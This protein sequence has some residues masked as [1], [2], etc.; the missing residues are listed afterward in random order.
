MVITRPGF[1]C[2]VAHWRK[3][4]DGLSTEALLKNKKAGR[5]RPSSVRFDATAGTSMVS[6]GNEQ[7][8]LGSL[9]VICGHL[10]GLVVTNE[11]VRNLLAIFEAGHASA[12]DSGDV[13]ENVLCAVFRLD[14]AKALGGIEP[15]YCSGS[16]ND[17][18]S[19]A[20]II[21]SSSNMLDVLVSRI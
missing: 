2:L 14:E 21:S 5:T 6:S 12:L 7:F 1:K 4:G 10:A 18:L 19:L 9:Q 17:F 20:N 3:T 15:F 16:H 8:E 13:D 11:F